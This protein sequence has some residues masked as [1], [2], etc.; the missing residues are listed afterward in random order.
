[1][2]FC[3]SLMNFS[4]V[5]AV[6]TR[7]QG[8]F[9][10]FK[11]LNEAQISD[12]L[13]MVR[14]SDQLQQHQLGLKMQGRPINLQMKKLGPREYGASASVCCVTHVPKKR[15]GLPNKSIF[16]LPILW[17]R[18]LYTAQQCCLGTVPWY[19]PDWWDEG[20]CHTLEGLRSVAGFLLSSRTAWTLHC[21]SGW[22]ESKGSQP[23]TGTVHHSQSPSVGSS[24]SLSLD[25]K[26]RETLGLY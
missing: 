9:L 6:V 2:F 11:N 1:M 20:L 25:S 19:W 10:D 26:G 4:S 3:F 7:I 15:S 22:Q 23:R 17:A 21:G 8:Y 12:G 18:T 5:H 14:G 24:Q 16:L 13:F